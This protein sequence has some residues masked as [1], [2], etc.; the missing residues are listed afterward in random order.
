MV[1]MHVFRCGNKALV[2]EQVSH[3]WVAPDPHSG[4]VLFVS[5]QNGQHVTFDRKD[6]PDGTDGCA[7]EQGLLAFIERVGR[8]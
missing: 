3:W 2:I 5:M 1:T 4:P 6:A 7:I 8:Q